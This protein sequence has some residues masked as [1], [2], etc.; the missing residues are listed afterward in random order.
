MVAVNIFH[1]LSLMA[2]RCFVVAVN[3]F[4]LLSLMA[5]VCGCC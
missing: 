3:I 5:L 4:H 2:S 1:L